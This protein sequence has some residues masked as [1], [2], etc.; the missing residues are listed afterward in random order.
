MKGTAVRQ[1]VRFFWF[2]WSLGAKIISLLILALLLSLLVQ[3]QTSFMTLSNSTTQATGEHLV[4]LGGEVLRSAYSRIDQNVLS[5]RTLALSPTLVEAARQANVAR[6]DLTAEQIAALDKAW[7][8]KNASIEPTVKEIESSAVSAYLKTFLKAFPDE[9]EVFATDKKGL[10]IAMTARTSDYLQAD[11]GWWKSAFAQSSSGA[12][13]DKAVYDE[14][15][16]TYAMNVGVPIFDP[17]TGEAIG[18]LRGTINITSVFDILKGVQVGETGGALLLDKDG[19]MIY[20]PNLAQVMKPAPQAILDAQKS[21]KNAWTRAE[22]QDG[23]PALVGL[24]SSSQGTGALLNW[25]LLVE[26]DL[27][28]INSRILNNLLSSLLPVGV[29][30]LI[31]IVGALLVTRQISSQTQTITQGIMAMGDGNL[32]QASRSLSAIDRIARQRDEVGAMGR[33]LQSMYAYLQEMVAVAKNIARGDLSGSVKPRSQQDEL[34]NAFFEMLEGLRAAVQEVAANAGAL[35]GASRQLAQASDQSGRAI[36]QIAQTIQQ[37]AKGTNQQAES[38]TSTAGAVDKMTLSIQSVASGAIE[39]QK[40]IEKTADLTG[41]LNGVIEK[42]S[43]AVQRDATSSAEA[44]N[45]SRDGAK[46][47]DTAVRSMNSIRSRVDQ[48]AVKVREMGARSE[49]IGV[50]VET[51]DEIASQTNLLALN[52]AIEAARAGEH[53]KGFAVVADEVRKLAERSSTATKEIGELVRGIQRT[54]SEAVMAM[55]ESLKEVDRGVENSNQSGM[56]LQRILKNVEVVNTGAMEAA[57]LL[58]EAQRST[59]DLV[60]A[61]DSVSKVVEK[62]IQATD[63]MEASARQVS[64]AVENIASVSE[65]N[66]AAVQEV[67]ASTEE[68]NAQVEEVNASTQQLSEMAAALEQVVSR[69]TLK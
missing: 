8:D 28:E 14:S 1:E 67:S 48:S 40:A 10:N 26:Q 37:V 64:A 16:K 15:A 25:T 20:S 66:S 56:A 21:T 57:G 41:R 36:G 19:L 46:T 55:D 22:D 30:V 60:N 32:N 29:V 44:A 12:F 3:V 58:A 61:M 18:V 34:G 24:A 9:V 33:A 27:A 69:F 53:G 7:I 47:V 39:Q 38:V 63:A 54:V 5:L 68:I 23:N 35:T 13:V 51:I 17:Q 11:E 2:H 31:V 59:N 42:I 52:A 49:Q 6:K 4:D 62:N 45:A 65:E 50:I 43:E